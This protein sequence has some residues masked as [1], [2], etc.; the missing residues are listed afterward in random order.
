MKILTRDFGEVEAAPE[1]IITFASPMF[2]FEDLTQYIFLFAEENTNFVWLQ[3]VENPHIC[4]ILA[5]PKLVEDHY[6]PKLSA[7]V[8]KQLGEGEYLF[9][10]VVVVAQ[11]FP[12]STINMKSP[13]IV[14][15]Q[16]KRAVQTILDEDFPI[17]RPLVGSQEGR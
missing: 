6:T 2:G 15:L 13:V 1:D 5:D 11:D 8:Q 12:K 14:N 4:F 10:L 3:S 9:W 7:D 16:T 17:R